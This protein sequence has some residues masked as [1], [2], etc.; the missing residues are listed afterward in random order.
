MGCKFCATGE[1]GFTR[2]LFA[3]EILEQ[4]WHARQ[5]EKIDNITFM[6][7]GEPLNNFDEVMISI[8][9]VSL[10]EGIQ[11]VFVC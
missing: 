8:F 10:A 3:S 11:F 5:I 1:M 9:F 6:G 2:S 7:Q 4:V